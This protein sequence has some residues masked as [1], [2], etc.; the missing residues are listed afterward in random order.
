MTRIKQ[1][2][3]NCFGLLFMVTAVL[4]YSSCNSKSSVDEGKNSVTF[5]EVPLCCGAA[6]EIGCGSRIKPFFIETGN[7]KQIAESWSNRQGT[8]IALKWDAASG[9]AGTRER[10]VK[11]LFKK[12][13]IRA[14]LVSNEKKADSLAA[15]MGADKWYKGMAVDE[16]SLE[17][18]GVISESLTGFALDKALIDKTEKEAIKKDLDAYFKKEL[19]VVRTADELNSEGLQDKWRSDGYQIYVG[20]I[21]KERA[22][23]VAAEFMKMQA[24]SKDAEACEDKKACCEEEKD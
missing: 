17:E 19:V 14:L 18:A 2:I 5:Y 10:M 11:P 24:S 1:K 15:S 12:H 9:D 16:L 6:P 3:K 13:G 21:G 20:H 4:T 7:Q 8:I 23:K 22:D